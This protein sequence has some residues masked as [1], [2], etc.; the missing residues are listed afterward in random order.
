MIKEINYKAI[1]LLW[2]ILLSLFFSLGFN[3]SISN[4]KNSNLLNSLANWDGA[5]Y[6]EIAKNG[7]SKDNYFAFFP[8]F[9]IL[10]KIVSLITGNFLISA[11]IIN[12]SSTFLGLILFYKLVK[13]E[14]NTVIAKKSLLLLLI[15]PTSFFFLT[16][17]TESLFFLLSVLSFYLIFRKKYLFASICIV[18]A[19][20]VR[21]FG[22][23]LGF[24]F[25]TIILKK[26]IKGYK[27][28]FLISVL[29]IL[30]Y[31]LYLY[32]NTGNPVYFIKAQEN[33]SRS[34][35]LPWNP[36]HK[37]MEDLI[38]HGLNSQTFPLFL[39]LAFTIFG[40]GIA[41]RGFRFLPK[42]YSLYSVFSLFL[43]LSTSLLISM[44]RFLLVIFP[45]FITLGFIKHKLF[46][47]F[48]ICISVSLLLFYMI[49]FINGYWVS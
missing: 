4:I 16:V 10:I 41:I 2:F 48:Y 33:W 46:L 28:F 5:Y 44:P 42:S 18:L 38:N 37:G 15:F 17:Y 19:S 13:D 34:F 9:P 40:L 27:I 49:L 20:L 14:F 7:Y 23:I 36:I 29:G 35:S 47:S 31:F 8:L 21:P 6:L 11:L 32:I 3:S 39:N 1:I 22:I 43:A 26:R 45:L 12:F 25:W 30:T 24:I